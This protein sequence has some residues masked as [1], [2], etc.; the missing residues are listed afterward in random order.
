MKV[1]RIMTDQKKIGLSP[2]YIHTLA[3]C[4]FGLLTLAPVAQAQDY[5]SQMQA[6]S[7]QLGS[8]KEVLSKISAR[9]LL[10]IDNGRNGF[11]QFGIQGMELPFFD[12]RQNQDKVAKAFE[13]MA[14]AGIQSVRTAASTWH[15]LSDN[16]NNF[17]EL[18]FVVNNG[19]KYGMGYLFIVGYPPAKFNVSP[20]TLSTFRPDKESSFRIYLNRVFTRYQG[21]VIATEVGN[22]VD[23]VNS[24]W[25]GATPELYV[26][27]CRIVKEEATKVDPAIKVM[28]FAATAAREPSKDL[29]MQSLGRDF[30]RKSFA[31]GIDKYIDAYSLHYTWKMSERL[32]DFFNS[33][34]ASAGANK[35]LITSE[36]TAYG[37]PSEVIK[38]FARD[39]YLRG[40]QSVYYYL[41]RDYF[42]D[43][44]LRYV[45]LF[46]INW[47]PKLRLL[48]YAAAVDAMKGSQLVG[49]ASPARNIEAYVLKRPSSASPAG[50]NFS[51]VI[52]KNS[53]D[54]DDEG[55]PA[56]AGP[57]AATV[58]GLKDVVAA[59]NWKLD[60]ISLTKSTSQLSVTTDPVIVYTKSLPAWKL[61]SPQ[62]W[63]F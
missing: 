32:I 8:Q 30:I 56:A 41:A 9:P 54:P 1:K 35:P 63:S 17:T 34:M 4:L 26:R 29:R 12:Y 24:W 39:F 50:A 11:P 52:W 6:T 49:M 20:A 16:A 51:I 37:R 55:V 2:L 14:R 38:L 61:I 36:D 60:S 44:K 28:A 13:L 7:E 46:D 25:R 5:Q 53:D 40:L 58:G 48:A 62:N 47:N 31:A 57:S 10:T 42:E 15:R 59:S 21:K 33:A 18:D 19:S 43:G 45:G 3:A 22:E 23:A 27:D